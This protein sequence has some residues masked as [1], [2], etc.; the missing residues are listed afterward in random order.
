MFISTSV[1]SKFNQHEVEVQTNYD[2]KTISIAPKPNGYGS[3]INGAELLLLSLAT[4]CCND[5]YRE[6]GKRNLPVSAVEVTCAGKFGGEG[7]TGSNFRYKVNEVSD[8]PAEAIEDLISYVDKI[9]EVH[10]T[11]RKG[12]SISLEK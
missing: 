9:A 4:C 12:L 2:S 10:N 8:A 5:I 1:K 3:S 6:A 7:E 11:L